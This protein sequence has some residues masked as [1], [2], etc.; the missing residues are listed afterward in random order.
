ML[1]QACGPFSHVY[2]F[3]TTRRGLRTF[4]KRDNREARVGT[5]LAV[6]AI[7]H[8]SGPDFATYYVDTSALRAN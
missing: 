1:R 4:T 3:H 6:P 5:V 2:F 7:T 8:A